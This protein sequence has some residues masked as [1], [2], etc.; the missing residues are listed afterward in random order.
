MTNDKRENNQLSDESE[1]CNGTSVQ[2]IVTSS[3]NNS[4][5]MECGDGNSKKR[6]KIKRSMYPIKVK[7][8]ILCT[9]F[10]KVIKFK[11]FSSR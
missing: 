7:K 5:V 1:R 11:L 4:G 3:V 8:K 10:M 2:S 9:Y 6:G